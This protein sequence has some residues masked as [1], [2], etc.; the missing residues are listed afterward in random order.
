[1]TQASA[2]SQDLPK[3]LMTADELL[4]L[5]RGQY[6]YELNNGELTTMSPSGA[7]HG[8]VTLILGRFIGNHVAEH[9]LGVVFGAET[10]FRLTTEPDTVLAPDVAFVDQARI[11]E[12]GLPTSFFNGSPDLAVEVTSPSDRQKSID[13]KVRKWLEH[14]CREVWVVNPNWRNVTVYRSATDIRVFNEPDELNCSDVLHGFTCHVADIFP[15][16]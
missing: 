1:M 3:K 10:G 2:K 6:R 9:A 16:A 4:D 8:S 11:Q 12:D 7:R 15:K 5:P 13:D 14:G